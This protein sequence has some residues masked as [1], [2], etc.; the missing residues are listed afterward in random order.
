MRQVRAT[1]VTSLAAAALALTISA[2]AG[3][4]MDAAPSGPAGT[5]V[6]VGVLPATVE[7][8]PAQAVELTAVVTGAINTAVS[9]TVR[10]VGGGT[11]SSTG[12]YVA[13]GA[14]GTFHVVAASVADP[15]VSSA[16]TITVTSPPAPVVVTVTPAT[17]S[18]NACATLALTAAV[19]GSSNGAVTWSVQEGAAG[20]AISA[21]GVY[22]APSTGGIYHLVATSV[23]DPTKKA[24]ATVTVTERVLSV[25]VTPAGATIPPGGTAQF[26]ATVTTTCGAFATVTTLDSAG[27]VVPN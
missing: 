15:T 21:S 11:V 9:W 14:A 26:T 8:Q 23:A 10:E 3:E 22:T 6:T 7:L 24:S 18:I 2:C 25:Q 12:R 17:G 1:R 19:T 27:Q 13:P 20:G 4:V 5:T 16:A